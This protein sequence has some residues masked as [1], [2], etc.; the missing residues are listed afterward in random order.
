MLVEE[1]ST[2]LVLAGD[3][4]VAAEV[5]MA[6]VTVVAMAEL[7]EVAVHVLFQDSGLGGRLGEAADTSNSADVHGTYA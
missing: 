6:V 4:F 1:H 7:H 5:A 3:T 2:L